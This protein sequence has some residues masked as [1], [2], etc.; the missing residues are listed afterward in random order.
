MKA[1]TASSPT[2]RSNSLNGTPVFRSSASAGFR[3]CSPITR[4]RTAAPMPLISAAVT[5]PSV[6]A[7]K[8]SGWRPPMEVDRSGRMTGV[9]PKPSI[10]SRISSTSP[11]VRWLPASTLTRLLT[12]IGAG[13]TMASITAVTVFAKPSS[14]PP[15]KSGVLM[16]T[17]SQFFTTSGYFLRKMLSAPCMSSPLV[18]VRPVLQTPMTSGLLRS[19]MVSTA[20][21]RLSWPPRMV[22][23]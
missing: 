21:S 9:R 17:T 13:S 19:Y 6:V 12:L 3:M 18:S 4:V 5:P 23:T 14:R 15:V 8:S 20:A 10:R 11:G 7:L 22:C 16:K 1:S 2:S